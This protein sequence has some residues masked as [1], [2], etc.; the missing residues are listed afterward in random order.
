[1]GKGREKDGAERLA[2]VG[3]GISAMLL[4]VV[5]A[6]LYLASERARVSGRLG[7]ESLEVLGGLSRIEAAI[8]QS[9]SAQRGRALYGDAR[10]LVQRDAALE[11]AG[12][13]V[14]RLGTLTGAAG[15]DREAI[16]RL[17]KLVEQRAQRM[18]DALALWEKG[19]PLDAQTP[20][21]GS[22]ESFSTKIYAMTDALRGEELRALQVHRRAEE[23][24]FRFV[25]ALL[26][27]SALLLF[28]VILP[29]YLGF[30]R[31]ARSRARAEGRMVEL[32]ESL[33]GA[34]FQARVW[35]G[36]DLR[37]EFLSSSTRDVRGVEREAAL[38]DARI[39]MGTIHEADVKT[40]RETLAWAAS[41]MQPLDFD[42]RIHHPR[43]GVRW[44][45]SVSTPAKQPDGS[46]RWSGHWAD[47]TTQKEMEGGLLR[48]MEEAAAANQAKGRFLAT[49][50]H[51]IRT[52]MNGVLAMLELLSLTRLDEE[53]A[54]SLA[55]VR[56]S[57]HALL[58]IIDD[59]LDFSK[60]EAG[61]MDV[62]PQAASI[63]RIVERVVNVHSGV[64]SAKGLAMTT[65]VDPAISPAL[66]FDPVRVQ[67]ILGNLV[68]NAI[69][70]TPHGGVSISARL[71]ERRGAED[72][73]RL[74]VRDS[75]IGMTPE[76]QAR[77]FEAFTQASTET[78]SRFGGTGLGLA[79]SRQLTRLMGGT[80]EMRSRAGIGTEIRV[81]LPMRV[82]P[83]EA[84][85]APSLPA[86]PAAALARRAPPPVDAAARSGRLVLVV[87]DHPINRTV[88]LK[89]VNALGFA[90]ET[91]ESGAEALEKWRDGRYALLLLDCN[92]PEVSGYDVARAI[93]EREPEEGRART[94]IIACTANAM[95]GEAQ[96]CLEAG[97]DDY[98]VKPIELGQLAAKLGR[99]LGDLPLERA[100]LDEICGGDEAAAREV[101]DRFRR[102]NDEDARE[103]R[104]ALRDRSLEG[105]VAACHRIKG[106]AKTVGATDLAGAAELAETSARAADWEG[107][108]HAMARFERELARLEAW[109]E[110]ARAAA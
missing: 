96:K 29:A 20:P 87:D 103:L 30:L 18:R 102:C 42:Y 15:L 38:S 6:A 86:V 4:V 63:A 8:A 43:K 98:L 108:G 88:L 12:R 74:E 70:F 9:Q 47:I 44:I 73:V 19:R 27:G 46:V 66:L 50:S 104:E 24:E 83:A 45:R 77:V 57:G 17:A 7:D 51:E 53:Q 5:G 60:I 2:I 64:A 34:V 16:A 109:M 93:R 89:Q 100:M 75:G 35:P 28:A 32:A 26:A 3:F 11:R 91:A 56:E 85:A 59:I 65:S 61:K 41:H 69:K 10:F 13:E 78:T 105:V 54:A 31:Q 36:G 14:A 107:I 79:I 110:A 23:S 101:L 90:A 58:R 33:P 37:Y 95:L 25:Y 71:L 72:V 40:F 92:M 81:T 106:A 82:A 22:A 99:F 21:P 76:E 67:Q 55:V 48:A 94:P 84:L 49:M 68:N 52:P 80:I 39:L 1:M 97:M 62:V